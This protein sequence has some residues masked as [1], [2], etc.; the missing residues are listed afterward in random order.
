MHAIADS[1]Q[2]TNS[3]IDSVRG[4][5]KIISEDGFYSKHIR[6]AD[7]VKSAGVNCM[8]YRINHPII[9]KDAFLSK[10]PR[11]KIEL[12]LD[13]GIRNWKP[14]YSPDRSRDHRNYYLRRR[15]LQW[16]IL[17]GR[18]W[19]P[20]RAERKTDAA[21]FKHQRGRID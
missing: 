6:S 15:V 19:K 2:S 11:T 17:D 21:N 14:P 16:Y 3:S 4:A 8:R 10:I 20:R 5:A 1:N 7:G 12:N 13:A 9:F 18:Q